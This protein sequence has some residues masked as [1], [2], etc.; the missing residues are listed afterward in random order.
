MPTKRMPV[1]S[2]SHGG[3]PWPWLKDSFMGDWSI[4]E[5]SLASIPRELNR[6][7]AAIVCVTAHWV[8]PQF[9]VGSAATPPMLYDYGGFPDFTYRITYS[10]P[11]SP[12]LA[13]RVAELLAAAGLP[14]GQDAE[15]GFDHGTFV[16]LAV[17]YPAADVPVVQLSIRRDFDPATHLHAGRALA[18]LRDEDVL[19]VCSG[20]PT[21]HNFSKMG[22][23][24][25]EPS[26]P[27]RNPT[28]LRANCS[29]ASATRRSAGWPSCRSTC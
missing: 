23:A 5:A 12:T 20:V 29:F 18:P 19:I 7:P 21:F 25:T 8:T 17:A 28:S 3:G 1:Y 10:A 15:R 4:L 16:P 27:A 9:T 6:V 22:P 24:S 13:G 2:I 11:G 14:V 26:Q